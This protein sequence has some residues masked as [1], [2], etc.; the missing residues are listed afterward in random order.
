S[1]TNG[2]IPGQQPSVQVIAPSNSMLPTTPLDPTKDSVKKPSPSQLSEDEIELEVAVADKLSQKAEQFDKP[3]AQYYASGAVGSVNY[4]GVE[5]VQGN[6]SAGASVGKLMPNGVSVEVSFAYSN[7]YIDEYW[8]NYRFFK[9][10]DQYNLGVAA[11]YTLDFGLIRPSF[12]GIASYV[13]R[14]YSDREYYSY[15]NSDA[16]EVTSHAIDLGLSL[17]LDISM[18]E[19]FAVGVEYRYMTN[20]ANRADSDYLTSRSLWREGQPV[21]KTDYDSITLTGKF[22]F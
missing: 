14:K 12:G 7:F 19:G 16:S 3:Q 9:E 10:M 22:R 2:F 21:E 4:L 20:L 17:G 15:S 13:Y 18:S 6:I 1:N 5:N 11:K 8:W